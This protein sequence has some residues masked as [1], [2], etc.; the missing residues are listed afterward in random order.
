MHAAYVLHT[1]AYRETSLLVDLITAEFGRVSLVARGAKRGKAKTSRLLQPFIP[2][3]VSWYG[4]GEL[5]TLSDVEASG[6]AHSLPGKSAICGLYLNELLMRLLP[7]WDPCMV[8]FAN[9]QQA[10]LQINTKPQEVLRRFEK[11]LLTNLGYA[12]QLTVD[13]ETGDDIKADKHYMYDPA[14]GL[15]PVKANHVGAL[16]GTSL[17]ALHRDEYYP[18]MLADAKRLMRIVLS[19]YMGSK[20]LVTRELL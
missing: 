8:T 18:E 4:N 1:R 14:L 12:L 15:R 7:K 2:L 13:V 17:I 3:H 20:K 6:P 16:R 10:L 9:Y 19:Y 11:E 5:V